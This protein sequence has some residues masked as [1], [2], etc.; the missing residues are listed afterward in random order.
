MQ[1]LC[2]IHFLKLL[3]LEVLG[4]RARGDWPASGELDGCRLLLGLLGFGSPSAEQTSDVAAGKVP[5]IIEE[6]RTTSG[7]LFGT[8]VAPTLELEGS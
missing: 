8:F 6:L 1:K 7:L 4:S 5:N 2:Y 3:D